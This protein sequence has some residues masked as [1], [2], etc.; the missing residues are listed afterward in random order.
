MKIEALDSSGEFFSLIITEHKGERIEWNANDYERGNDRSSE[1]VFSHIN[2]YFESMPMA[3]QDKIWECYVEIKDAIDN[4]FD[5]NRLHS[6]LTDMVAKLYTFLPIEDFNHWINIKSGI[7]IPS[8]IKPEYDI[9]D[10]VER[11]YVRADYSNLILLSLALRPMV[12]IWSEYNTRVKSLIGNTF[13]EYQSMRLLANTDL[14]H[15]DAMEKLR[16]YVETN[17]AAMNESSGDGK[18]IAAII[19]GLGTTEL[20]GWLLALAVVRRVAIADLDGNSEKGTIIANVYKYVN[21][22][23]KSLDKRFKGQIKKKEQQS[24]DDEDNASVIEGYKVKQEQSDGDLVTLSIF[25]ENQDNIIKRLQPDLDPVK[26]NSCL[27]TINSIAELDI[28]PHQ[29]TLTQ[30]VISPILPARGV[31]YLNKQ[32]LLSIMAICQA[33]L[34]HRGFEDL[35]KL[36]TAR[37]SIADDSEIMLGGYEGRSLIPKELMDELIRLYPYYPKLQNKQQGDRKSNPASKAIDILSK[38][39]VRE[40][41]LLLAPIEL[42]G[43]ETKM[44]TPPDIK[45]QLAKFIIDR[46]KRGKNENI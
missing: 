7:F 20:P 40:E 31:P 10:M 42:T 5:A 32:G 33:V 39:L 8:S 23:I 36:I 14:I 29:I 3:A 28:H 25:T 22:S 1:M 6:F 2:R 26:L 18:S 21:N 16:D 4:I 38:D 30:W 46:T 45:A 37:P 41:W 11:T 12:P 9:E 43:G 13:K 34:W 19:G 17:A 15:H 24:G 44:F 35:A 27:K